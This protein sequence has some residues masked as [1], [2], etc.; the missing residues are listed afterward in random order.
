MGNWQKSCLDAKVF[1]DF[2]HFKML[3]QLSVQGFFKM[4]ADEQGKKR[5]T[6]T[7]EDEGRAGDSQVDNMNAFWQSFIWGTEHVTQ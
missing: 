7:K 6:D 5:G 3:W 2:S 1:F 4:L